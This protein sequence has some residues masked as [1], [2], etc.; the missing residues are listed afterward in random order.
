VSAPT[1]LLGCGTRLLDAAQE[2][3][4]RG[5]VEQGL[6]LLYEGLIDARE[7]LA[8][9]DW[10][11]Y[12]REV[13]LAHPIRE[14]IHQDPIARRSF[15]KPRGYAGD[16][17]LL[18]HIYGHIGPP[19]EGTLARE[20][21]NFGM[22]R[23]AGRGVRRRRVI[24]AER[25]DQVADQCRRPIRVLS[26][27]SGHLREL[28]DSRAFQAGQ[29]EEFVALDVDA[30]SL[31]E[32]QREL[33]E[34]TTV[35]APFVALYRDP[36]FVPRFDFIYSAGLYD[37]LKESVAEKLTARMFELLA[38]GGTLLVTNFLTSCVDAAY[39]DSL[40]DWQLIYRTRAEVGALARLI[41]AS[42]QG[43]RREFVDSLRAIGY[44]ELTRA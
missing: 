31:A 4:D 34:V 3:I 37:Y 6:E 11:R 33:P 22:N 40:M 5:R 29:V 24:L 36:R 9:E 16:A 39:M 27:A 2:Q 14:R 19:A 28:A 41:P 20:I 23:P 35:H 12:A 26:V 1:S 44:L 10:L 32:V 25:I 15:E 18:D 21:Y 13:V 17:V 43:P 38:P 42:S 30:E 7:Q 8:G